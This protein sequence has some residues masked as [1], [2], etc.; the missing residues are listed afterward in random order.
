MGPCL[1]AVVTVALVV[2]GVGIGEA[3]GRCVTEELH[4]QLVAHLLLQLTL[5]TL[6]A[7]RR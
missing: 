1:G 3:S 6:F 2:G 5:T 4:T 7:Q